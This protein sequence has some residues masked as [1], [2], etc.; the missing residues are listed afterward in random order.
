MHHTGEQD[1]IAAIATPPGRGGIAIVRISGP[2]AV[3]VSRS[4]IDYPAT[5]LP[6][7]MMIHCHVSDQGDHID[8]VLACVMRAPR[9]YTGEDVVELQCHGGNAAARAILEALFRQGIR[10][11]N[12]GEFTRRAFENGRIDLVQAESVMEIISSESREHLRHAELLMDG[13]FSR[14]LESMLGQI[15]H[16]MSLLEITIDFTDQGLDAPHETELINAIN[17]AIDTIDSMLATHTTAR[18]VRDGVRVVLTGPVNAG[19]S[20]LFNRLLGRKR[21]IV[22]DTPGTTRD[23][24]EERI[25]LDG[26]P[27]NLVDTAGLRTT[28]DIVEREGVTEAERLMRESDIV[29][30]L[31]EP[32]QPAIDE[33]E[34]IP[35]ILP[36]LSK[37][38]LNGASTGLADEHVLAVSSRTGAGIDALRNELS[39][40][41]RDIVGIRSTDTL[42]LVERHRIGLSN[43]HDAL[44]RAR[45]AIG[46]WSEEIITFELDTTRKEIEHILGRNIDLA[47]LDNI[48]NRFCIGK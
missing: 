46:S 10:P 3:A 8:E 25:E 33:N 7:R 40:L 15:T 30:H 38:D 26:I 35:L 37:S 34:G 20:S 23:W 27:I 2:D 21:A 9:S 44:I 32:G 24:I 19:K 12:P 43:A 41:C 28:G 39:R 48:F 47:V 1:T 17:S 6:D 29:L 18:R 4:L 13:A 14:R 36:V 31:H 45:T 11:A 5:E 16:A 22:S 42:V